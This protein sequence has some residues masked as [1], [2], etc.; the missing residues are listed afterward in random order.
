MMSIKDPGR[1]RC[2]LPHWWEL[3]DP[4]GSFRNSNTARK[5]NS[6]TLPA[7]LN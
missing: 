2:S 7:T 6:D 3:H 4:A 1:A 5:S